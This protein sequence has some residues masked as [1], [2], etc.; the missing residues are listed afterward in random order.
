MQQNNTHELKIDTTAF[1]AVVTK[2]KTAE[3]RFNDRDYRV[4]DLL[5]LR[6]WLT[7]ESCFSGFQAVR[8][9]THI[10]TGYGIPDGFVMLSMTTA[11]L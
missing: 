10:Q 11:E 8:T 7:D 2:T 6:E 5:V 1:K 4:G 9:I 3:F